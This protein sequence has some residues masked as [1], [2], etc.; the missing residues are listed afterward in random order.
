MAVQLIWIPI[1][2]A[3]SLLLRFARRIASTAR[4]FGLR[5]ANDSV[6]IPW[7][8]I[9]ERGVSVMVTDGGSVRLARGCSL[10]ANMRIVVQGGQLE[11]GSRT[12]VGPGC[13]IVVRQSVRLGERV[14]VGEYVT[15]RD[16]DHRIDGASSIMDSGFDVS[17]IDIGD[18]VW[19]G[20]KATVLRGSRLE[21]GSVVG[22]HALVRGF[23]PKGAIVVGVPAKVLRKRALADG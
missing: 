23:V 9:V 5:A 1:R 7:S 16:Q 2:K 10:G 20:A 22:A 18:D 8:T 12:F 14:L 15:I 21:A 17:P 13:V 11:L 3:R 6:V 4:I 19:L